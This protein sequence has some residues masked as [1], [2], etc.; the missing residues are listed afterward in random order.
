MK[1]LIENFKRFIFEASEADYTDSLVRMLGHENESVRD[2]GREL[3]RTL[4]LDYLK[5]KDLSGAKLKNANL[6]H[7]DLTG[8]DLRD[9]D[10]GNANLS[11]VIG[12]ELAPKEGANLRLAIM[13]D[14]TINLKR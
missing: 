13:P 5:G 1:L 4:G 7:A 14:G 12:W 6:R 8:T 9:A 3:F 2:Q 10:L 11:G